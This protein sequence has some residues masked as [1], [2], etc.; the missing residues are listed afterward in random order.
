M[1]GGTGRTCA[2]C[3]L[4][5]HCPDYPYGSADVAVRPCWRPRPAP[6]E[7]ETPVAGCEYCRP[8]EALYK[9]HHGAELHLSTLAGRRTLRAEFYNLATPPQAEHITYSARCAEFYINFCPHCGRDLR[10]D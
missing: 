1:S 8:S 4:A 5:R 6:E 7:R 2:T 10:G 9:A 3:G